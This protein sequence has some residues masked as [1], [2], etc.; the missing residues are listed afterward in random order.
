VYH[1]TKK[2]QKNMTEQTETTTAR[3]TREERVFQLC[4]DLD[5]I[6]DRKKSSSKAYNDEIKRIQEEIDNLINPEKEEEDL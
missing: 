6:K 2:K 3:T 5:E 4:K 1:S